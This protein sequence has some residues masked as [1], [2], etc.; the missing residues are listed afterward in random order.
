MDE[1]RVRN[2]GVSESDVSLTMRG[3]CT[4][5]GSGQRMRRREN[6]E[7]RAELELKGRVSQRLWSSR[8]S[9]TEFLNRDARHD[10]SYFIFSL[11]RRNRI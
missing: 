2:T 4:W 6:R 7:G 5:R 8:T 1:T 10:F 11:A 3:R 9:Q